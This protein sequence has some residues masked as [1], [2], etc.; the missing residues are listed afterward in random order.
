[1]HSTARVHISIITPSYNQVRFIRKTIE[2]VLNQVGEFDLEYLVID[3][4]STDGT[5]AILKEYGSRLAWVSEPDQGQVEAINKGLQRCSGDVIGWLNSD[6]VLLPGAVAR[7]VEEL[8]HHP[9]VEWVHGRCR[10]IDENDRRVRRW[11]EAYKHYRSMRYSFEALLMEN[12]ISQMTVFWRRSAMEAIGYLDPG[13]P[14]A[15]D[16]DF[17]L[18]LAQRTGPIYI[19][20]PQA[21]FRLH[22]SSK[23]AANSSLQFRE[24]AEVAKRYSGGLRWLAPRKRIRN[25]AI[26]SIYRV[27]A[28]ARQLAQ[29]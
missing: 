12:F 29:R 24:N 10:I 15:F 1:M 18:R 19:E 13:F 6:D 8:Q 21:C 28:A 11:V 16:Y 20:S 25:A 5:V 3:G 17:W 14:L 9:E 26:V 23:S 2:S 22:G 7:A 4:G 27:L